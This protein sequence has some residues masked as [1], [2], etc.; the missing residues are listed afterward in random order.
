MRFRLLVWGSGWRRCE[1][2][3]SGEIDRTREVFFWDCAEL[4]AKSWDGY[5]SVYTL[6][7]GKVTPDT[8]Q[9]QTLG[10]EVI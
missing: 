2:A 10:N 5:P 6:E 8:S 3:G 7:T 4:G 9:G 1:G